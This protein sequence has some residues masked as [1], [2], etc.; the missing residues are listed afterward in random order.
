MNPLRHFEATTARLQSA[1]H[2]LRWGMRTVGVAH[3][4]KGGARMIDLQLRRPKRAEVT[5]R[6]GPTLEFDYPSQFPP[7]LVMFGDLIDPEYAF[8]RQIARPDWVIADVGAAI[9][10][11]SVFAA[12][13]PSAAVHAFEPSAANVSTLRRN[14]VRNGIVD[15]VTVNQAA[16]SNTSGEAVFETTGSTW[17]SHLSQEPAQGGEIVPVLTLP[18][19]LERAG[20]THLSVLKVNVSGFE[21]EVLEGAEPLL[22][23]GKADILIML[24][25]LRSLPW[26]ERIARHGYRFFYYHPIEKTLHE[27][28]AFDEAAV[29]DH[30]P[31]PARH[32]IA[33]HRAAI[34]R[35][36]LASIP[37]K[38]L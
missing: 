20:V 17:M 28:T 38:Q 6:S 15:K 31:W 23:A 25:G 7:I 1:A 24:L 11:F 30:R 34:D 13:L 9:G 5:L 10:Q 33:V 22:A 21:P 2:K 37:I 36:I 4:V 32:I 3:T 8:L 14:L 35:G 19:A 18:D 29:L 16:L 27:V 12:T 26:Y